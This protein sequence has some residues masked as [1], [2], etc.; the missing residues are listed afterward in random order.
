M[1]RFAANYLLNESGALLK[2]GIVEINDSGKVLQILDTNGDL[3]ETSRLNFQNGILIPGFELEKVQLTDPGIENPFLAL[4]PKT[5][6]LTLLQIIQA[7]IK[8]WEQT[9]DSTIS[10]FLENMDELL[11]RSGDYKK[12]VIPGIFLLIGCDL[13]NMKFTPKSRLKRLL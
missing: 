10:H 8:F 12:E 4:F 11:I 7:G 2:N 6:I 13:V 9:P 5:N 1:R 3:R